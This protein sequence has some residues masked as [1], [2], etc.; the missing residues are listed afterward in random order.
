MNVYCCCCHC[1]CVFV[2]LFVCFWVCVCVCVCVSLSLSLSCSG[3]HISNIQYTSVW[4]HMHAIPH[5][6]YH[7]NQ[8]YSLKTH[9]HQASSKITQWHWRAHLLCPKHRMLYCY[10][11]VLCSPKQAAQRWPQVPHRSKHKWSSLS[12]VPSADLA[13]APHPTPWAGWCVWRE[14][15]CLHSRT[16]TGRPWH[17]EESP[18]GH[19]T[20]TNCDLGTVPAHTNTHTHTHACMHTHTR[21]FTECFLNTHLS[22]L[23][24]F[25]FKFWV[26]IHHS[27]YRCFFEV[28][29]CLPEPD[30]KHPYNLWLGE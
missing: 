1:V 20:G 28:Q 21:L 12:L 13:S 17:S 18:S 24:L 30:T 7:Q 29:L 2:G 15:N 16:G 8:V 3:M 9:I 27:I 6:H 19:R 5:H 22:L 25:F 4:V 11:K 10:N 26:K 23:F 14:G